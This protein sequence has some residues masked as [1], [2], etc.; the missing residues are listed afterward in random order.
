[1]QRGLNFVE[2]FADGCDDATHR[3][4]RLPFPPGLVAAREHHALIRKIFWAELDS[5]RH[6][7]HFPII[8][9]E[10]GAGAFALIGDDAK[11]RRNQIGF[12]FAR[13]FD[14]QAAL[15]VGL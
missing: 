2:H 6:A 11:S 9:F 3:R 4:R 14:H 8:K 15:F 1:M 7:A 12:Q 13:S 5:Q 10:T